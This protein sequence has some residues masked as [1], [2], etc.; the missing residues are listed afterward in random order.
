MSGL[1]SLLLELIFW[2]TIK[3]CVIRKQTKVVIQLAMK[4]VSK[5]VYDAWIICIDLPSCR[6]NNLFRF[7]A[8]WTS[9][10]KDRKPDEYAHF[11]SINQQLCTSLKRQMSG[12]CSN[13]PRPTLHFT[14]PTASN[15][16][17][18]LKKVSNTWLLKKYLPSLLFILDERERERPRSAFERRRSVA[19]LALGMKCN[20]LRP[21]RSF[22]QPNT[23]MTSML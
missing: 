22:Q 5:Q 15:V 4:Q 1:N 8:T 13:I 12:S 6:C 18:R 10:Q 9:Y 23:H 14:L 3:F 17:K 7:D 21:K 19:P 2:P 16:S 20:N 11:R